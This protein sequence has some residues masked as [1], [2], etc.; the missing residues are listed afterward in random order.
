MTDIQTLVRSEERRE[1]EVAGLVRGFAPD[2]RI[3]CQ[4]ARTHIRSTRST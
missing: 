2:A 3:T 1:E 4:H